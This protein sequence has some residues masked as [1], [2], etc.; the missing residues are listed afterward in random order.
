MG[1]GN[2]LGDTAGRT[3]LPTTDLVKA[4]E[5]AVLEG[6]MWAFSFG[7]IDTETSLECPSEDV[8]QYLDI[9]LEYVQRG[10]VEIRT[11]D[12]NVRIVSLWRPFKARTF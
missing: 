7:H 8:E 5:E 2:S 6:A 3:V 1:E 10:L 9:Y 11:G 4:V 12:R